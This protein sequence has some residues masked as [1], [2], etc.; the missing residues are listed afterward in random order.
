[1]ARDPLIVSLKNEPAPPAM[2][3]MPPPPRRRRKRN[4]TLV[5]SV[6]VF[7]VLGASIYWYVVRNDS[8][9]EAPAVREETPEK[10]LSIVERVGKLIVLPEG[11]EPT[12][13]T[14]SDPSKLAEQTFFANAKV[15]DVVLIY[16]Q[17][18][19]AYLYDPN[20]DR[21]LEVAPIAQ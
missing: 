1:M 5:I 16:A 9:S 7:L 10:E 8:A 2:P 14:V 11:E 13:A 15:G 21:L 3:P 20:I 18:R 4:P 12:I 6:C 17:A 19:K